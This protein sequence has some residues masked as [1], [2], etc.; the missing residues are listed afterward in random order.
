MSRRIAKCKETGFG[1]TIHENLTAR[2]KTMRGFAGV[3]QYHRQR[4]EVHLARMLR[5]NQRTF[6]CPGPT[7][8]KPEA[9]SPA[10]SGVFPQKG[11][12]PL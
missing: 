2:Q 3:Y 12:T 5:S 4:R 8:M 6:E 9:F 10:P 11:K 7:A 1:K